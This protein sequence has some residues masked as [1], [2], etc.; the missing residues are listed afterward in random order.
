M[1]IAVLGGRGLI[2]DRL[3]TILA[4]TG[5]QVVSASRHTGVDVLTG[6]GLSAALKG[7]DVV[8]DVTDTRATDDAALAFFETGTRNILAAGHGASRRRHI[9]L[10]IVGVDRVQDSAYFRAK[11]LQEEI[12]SA[13]GAPFT[14]VRA[15]QFFE[16]IQRVVRLGMEGDVV[17]VPRTLLQPI[18]ADDVA[19][20]LASVAVTD[21]SNTTIELAGPEQICLN[22]LARLILSANQDPRDEAV[23]DDAR[24]FGAAL[25]Y[26]VLLPQPGARIAPGTIADWLRA[27]IT[28][29]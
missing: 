22:E 11:A 27:R 5:H 8:V 20:M 23:T 3:T 2:G 6:K 12:V 29:D 15:T 9:V 24:F 13:S 16:L 4:R 18:A 10:S 25:G 14:I 26:D 28:A 19:E 7:A 1:R 17:R 21:A